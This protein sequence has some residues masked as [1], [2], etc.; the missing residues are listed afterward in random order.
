MQNQIVTCRARVGA[1][2]PAA[3]AAWLLALDAE[4]EGGMSY[5]PR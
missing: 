3:P 5:V 1:I 4:D 2:A